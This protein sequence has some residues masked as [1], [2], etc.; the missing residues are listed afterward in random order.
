[1]RFILF[2][3]TAV[4][5][6]S[7]CA[8]FGPSYDEGSNGWP[9]YDKD[10]KHGWNWDHDDDDDKYGYHKSKDIGWTKTHAPKSYQTHHIPKTHGTNPGKDHK[11]ITYSDTPQY[12]LPTTANTPPSYTIIPQ[13]STESVASSTVPVIVPTPQP[14]TSLVPETS[15]RVVPSTT[16]PPQQGNTTVPTPP[17]FTG[18]AVAPTSQR[19]SLLITIGVVLLAPLLL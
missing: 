18:D 1:M 10:G 5:L 4:F 2:A 12:P 8:T 14:V 19:V 9:S 13:P 3:V 16:A 17:I 11:T 15:S 7:V 6:S